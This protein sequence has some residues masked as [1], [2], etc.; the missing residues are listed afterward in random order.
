M[1]TR[2]PSLVAFPLTTI[3]LA[4]CTIAGLRYQHSRLERGAFTYWQHRMDASADATRAALQTWLDERQQDDRMIARQAAKEPMLFGARKERA[5]VRDM[6]ALIT[7]IAN[8]RGYRG[9]WVLR[10]DGTPV[11]VSKEADSLPAEMRTAAIEAARTGTSHTIGPLRTENG[12]QLFA[13]MEPVVG[14]GDSAS[15]NLGTVVLG[16]DP[17]ISLFPIVL[18][19]LDGVETARH[20]LVQR[21]GDELVVLT[22]SRVPMAGPGELRIPW[23]RAPLAGTLAAGGHDTSGAFFG[24]N[25]VSVIAATRHIPETG[26]GI[27]RGIEQHEAYAAIE[28]EF[29]IEALFAATAFLLGLATAFA[30]RR[31]QRTMRKLAVAESESRYR[32]LAEHATDLIVRQD[33]NGRML[34]VSPACKQLLGYEP[35]EFMAMNPTTVVHPDDLEIARE[36][37]AVSFRNPLSLPVQTRMRRA[38][39]GF[40]WFETTGQPVVD[41]LTHELTEIVTVSRDISARRAVEEEGARLAQRNALLL[42]SAA[43]GIFGLDVNG[44]IIFMNPA[45]ERIVGWQASEVLGRSQHE[46]LH[47]AHDAIAEHP[48]ELCGICLAADSGRGQISHD[49]VFWRRDGSSFPVEFQS[50]PIREGSEVVGAVVT[51]RDVSARRRANRELVKAKEDAEAANAAKS[52]FLARMSHE[53][54]TPLNSVIGFSNV[55]RKNKTGNLNTQDLGY[56]ERIGKNGVQLLALINDILDLSKIEARKVSLEIGSVSIE[57]LVHDTLAQLGDRRHKEGVTVEAIVPSSL[58]MIDTDAAKLRQV[59]IN[60]IANAVKFTHAGT[61]TVVVEGDPRTKTPT[62]IRVIDTGIGIAPDRLAA[63]FAAFEQ[64]DGSTSREYGGTGLGLSISRALC[65]LLG[66]TLGVTSTLGSGSTFTIELAS[67]WSA[68]VAAGSI[69]SAIDS[70]LRGEATDVED[71]GRPLVLVIEDDADA[72]ELLRSYVVELGYRVALASSGEEGLRLADELRPQLITL[73]LMMPGMD[74]W[75][76]LKRFAATPELARIPVVIVSAIAG[77]MQDS[78]VGAVDW[79]DKPVR[80]ALLCEAI[81]RNVDRSEGGV[82]IVEDDPDARELLKRFV[83]E[84]HVGQLR[85]ASDGAVALAMLEH[86]MPD[87]VLLDLKMPAVDG[88][89]FL[90][91]IRDDPRLQHLAVIVVTALQLTDQQRARLAECTI[92]VL[93]KGATLEADIGRVLKSLPRPAERLLQLLET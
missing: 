90:D 52:D 48:P 35:L 75:E 38:N 36:A 40:A 53:L 89:R 87:L 76:L 33:A 21:M 71:E 77:E 2:L 73:D 14:S 28:H 91:T 7:E 69:G 79:I 58:E 25:D 32:L 3:V 30:I 47:H 1:P 24:M 22:P 78:F 44:R 50:T 85:L 55:L 45:A 67:P 15:K 54:R 34:Y 11:V 37:L 29:R 31:R 8:E 64:A 63:V 86:H 19:E 13:V 60:L 49:N 42:A 5:S 59:L 74:G 10:A 56:L 17:Y 66:F 93:E 18:R 43:E 39:G 61:V 70:R 41:P 20:R 9:I 83:C 72:R 26:W 23:A 62:R 82:L 57:E 46:L 6:S 4:A 12:E 68:P 88:F 65:E 92:A 81:A 16:I 51:F 84:E 27:V 80:H